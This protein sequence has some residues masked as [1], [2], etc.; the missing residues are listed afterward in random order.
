M[1]EQ[2][3]PE[4]LR[5]LDPATALAI[6]RLQLPDVQ[7]ELAMLRAARDEDEGETHEERVIREESEFLQRA[8]T[9]LY[10]AIP[11]S[12]CVVCEDIFEDS[13]LA[14][15]PCDHK[16]C[17]GCLQELFQ[18]SQIDESLFPPK[19]CGSM[20]PE[21]VREFLTRELMATHEE[22]RVEFETVD[23][24]Y[25]S[26]LQC[27]RFVRPEHITRDLGTCTTCNKSTCTKCKAT[28]HEGD[29]CP[30]D[31][32]TEA[33]LNHGTEQGW[34]RCFLCR[35]L[36]EMMHGCNHIT[37]RCGSEF[38]YQ[39]GMVWDTCECPLWNNVRQLLLPRP[40]RRN[41]AVVVAPQPPPVAVIRQAAVALP[42][43][44]LGAAVRNGN[45][46]VPVRPDAPPAQLKHPCLRLHYLWPLNMLQPRFKQLNLD[47]LLVP[48]MW[49]LPLKPSQLL[50]LHKMLFPMSLN[51]PSLKQYQSSGTLRN[52]QIS[53]IHY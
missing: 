6:V 50:M 21:Q 51:Y 25:C 35:S 3:L 33:L 7:N 38:C 42:L 53:L 30:R 32:T 31:E 43:R 22:K 15:A 37:C 18:R 39:C 46:Q 45:L 48:M 16:F 11:K 20:P 36:V 13:A 41:E 5:G 1:A 23:R 10:A 34:R 17:R 28:A 4:F 8:I 44:E 29:D 47:S 52:N 24:T 9:T 26:D 19:C 49:Q 12:P 2:Q 40:R 14:T 27:H